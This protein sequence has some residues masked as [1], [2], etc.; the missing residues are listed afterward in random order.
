[1]LLRTSWACCVLAIHVTAQGTTAIQSDTRSISTIT[2]SLNSDTA[3]TGSGYSY[4]SPTRQ[5][6]VSGSS[7]TQQSGTVSSS[8]SGF[9]TATSA[10]AG[11]TSAVTLLAGSLG[12]ITQSVINGSVTLGPNITA[13][14]SGSSTSTSARPLNTQPCNNYLEFCDRKYSNITEVCAHNSNFVKKGNA[15]SNQAL[16]IIDQ[17]NDGIRM[18]QGEVQYV[19][20][21]L[22][23]CHTS[24]NIL[25]AGTLESEL[26]TVAGWVRNHPYDVVTI[27]L[28][29]SDFAHVHVDK[30]VDPIQ[31]SGLA[32]YL[33]QPPYVPMHRDDWPTLA[34]MILSQKRVV[35]FMDY[36]AN[37][38]AVPYVLDQFTHMWETP[39]SPTNQSFP[40]TQQRPP[41]LNQT[42][43]KDQYMYML[44]HNLNLEVSLLGADILI[45]NTYELNISNSA[46]ETQFGALGVA[47]D[48]CVADWGHPP[49]F[50]LV[51]YY[52]VGDGSVFEVAAR[53]N[54]VTYNRKCCGLVQSAV[55]RLEYSAIA[56]ALAGVAA[57]LLI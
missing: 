46:S 3:F 53:H 45:P 36:N 1:M 22:W 50:L 37:Q 11:T 13:Q 5:V 33:Y 56:I 31:K 23:S 25:N 24:C 42:V 19:N 57:M 27:L 32:P 14:T 30:Y 34:E 17:L 10:A 41:G 16:P 8:G 29:N 39:F 18:I 6:T 40:C 26:A 7:T 54:N 21:S 52:N 28:V 44:N 43:A 47:A 4:L 12:Q 49:K 15:A 9:G 2:G 48:N 20:D 38:T 51:D 55:G 35:I